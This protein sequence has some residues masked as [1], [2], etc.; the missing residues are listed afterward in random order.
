MWKPGITPVSRYTC[1]IRP[2]VRQ[3]L[4]F[5]YIQHPESRT[6]GENLISGLH[7]PIRI[8]TAAPLSAANDRGYNFG[9]LTPYFLNTLQINWHGVPIALA[10][11]G[12]GRYS[13][14]SPD[15]PFNRSESSWKYEISVH[16]KN[17]SKFNH[18]PVVLG[19]FFLFWRGLRGSFKGSGADNS[20]ATI[21][22]SAASQ[23]EI[24]NNQVIYPR[25]YQNLK[26]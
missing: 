25:D 3:K 5:P 13:Y 14:S 10:K 9:S 1:L 17:L 8:K 22:N 19:G 21:N 11:N 4:Y 24:I 20:G 16:K 23:S 2:F 6:N 7:K 12:E 15:N 18:P 26:D